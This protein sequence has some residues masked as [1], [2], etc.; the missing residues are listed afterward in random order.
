[1]AVDA[2]YKCEDCEEAIW[3]AT[4]A[5][6]LQWLRS[7]RHLVREVRRHMSGGLDGWMEEGLAFLDRHDGHSIVVVTRGRP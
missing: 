6:E 2:G 3:L 7:R 4:S 5:P 1:M